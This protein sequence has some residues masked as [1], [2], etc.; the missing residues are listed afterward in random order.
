MAI[1]NINETCVLS[2]ALP[3]EFGDIE[4]GRGVLV[5]LNVIVI[6]PSVIEGN[7]VVAAWSFVVKDHLEEGAYMQETLL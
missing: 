5:A 6:G 7:V 4:I 1:H 2:Q 3:T